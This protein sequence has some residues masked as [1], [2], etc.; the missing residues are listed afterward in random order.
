MAL[1]YVERMFNQ[2]SALEN[3]N[4][5]DNWGFFAWNTGDGSTIRSYCGF[6]QRRGWR[7]FLNVPA[8][9]NCA[10]FKFSGGKIAFYTSET[11]DSAPT[12]I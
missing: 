6:V 11:P 8:D 9:H 12:P 2:N 10:D 5:L 1:D 7:E 4:D 3:S